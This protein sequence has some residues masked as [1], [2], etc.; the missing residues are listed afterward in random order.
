MPVIRSSGGTPFTVAEGK[1]MDEPSCVRA[2]V[3]Y[4]DAPLRLFH[5][6]AAL[7]GS[8]GVFSDGYG[9]GIIGIS[10]SGAAPLLRLSP[11]WMGLL[12]G[13][14]LLGLLAGALLTGPAADCFGRR[15]SFAYN[16]AVLAGLSLLQGL[17]DSR[18]TLLVL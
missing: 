10:L 8:V 14:S 6:R 1:S 7:A 16:M 2:T 11:V 3:D 4:D 15:P 17:T 5:L 12:G 9:L 13:A 18:A